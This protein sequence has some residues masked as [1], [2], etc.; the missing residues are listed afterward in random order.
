[1]KRVTLLFI[2][3]LSVTE[4]FSQIV[5]SGS[6]RYAKD[7]SVV[8]M[9]NVIIEDTQKK[10]VIGSA[11]SDET[12]RFKISCKPESSTL[13]LT[14][15]GFNIARHSQIIKAQSQEIVIEVMYQE[16]RLKGA[17]IKVE[18]IKRTGDTL[19]YYVSKF[20][21]SLDRSIG[22]VLKKM[23]GISVDRSGGI[24]YNGR[25][26]TKF[27][28]E[29]MDMMGA[30]YGVATKNVQ[31]RDI[32]AVE[33]YENHQPV[34]MFKDLK[35]SED[36]AINLKL[37][38]KSK[39]VLIATLQLGAG[40]KPWS[41]SGMLSAMLF[42]NSYQM[43]VSAKTNN[44]GEDIITE[45]VEQFDNNSIQLLPHIGVYAP[46]KPDIDIER[47]MKNTTHAISINNL[48]KLNKDKVLS[49]NSIYSYD[50]QD[51]RDSSITVYYMPSTSPLKIGEA[52]GVRSKTNHAEMRLKF[53]ENG[54]KRY[55]EDVL[56]LQ[57]KWN[58]AQGEVLTRDEMINQSFNMNPNLRVTNEFNSAKTFKN[59]LFFGFGSIIGASHLPASLCVNPLIY[60]SI[61]GYEQ[62]NDETAIQ[63]MSTQAFQT[64]EH[65][66]SLYNI[67]PR[68]VLDAMV[69]FTLDHQKMESSLGLKSKSEF[70]D[71]LCNDIISNKWSIDGKV[72]LKYKYKK[73]DIS[74]SVDIDYAFIN[75]ND[76]IKNVFTS[77][78]KLFFKPY[79]V[80]NLA[81]ALNLKLNLKSYYTEDYGATGNFYSGYILTDYRSISTRNGD[82]A[83]NKSQS[84]SIGLKYADAMSA[85]FASVDASYWRNKSNIMYGTTFN[86]DLSYIES[87]HIDNITHGYGV[88]GKVSKF[89]DNIFTTLELSGGYEQ[90]WMDIFRQHKVMNTNNITTKAGFKWI[91][92]WCKNKIKSNYT[93]NYLYNQTKYSN[94]DLNITSINALHQVLTIDYSIINALVFHLVGEHYFNNAIAYGS[95]NIYFLDA[96][97]TFKTQKIEYMLEARNL[98]NTRVY[99][100]N[101]TSGATDF[102]YHYLLRPTLVMLKVKFKLN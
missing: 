97:L 91:T 87:Y 5:I 27:Y 39:G 15:A 85:L 7:L 54:S 41:W 70:P 28:V 22:D 79:F 16:I 73:L 94:K 71:T 43:F 67:A 24:K 34:K 36:A 58:Q 23:P 78:S 40:Y 44:S 92:N 77:K 60:P 19:T 47:Y 56:T 86:G 26:I 14:V 55:I 32:A 83:E 12:G 62:A 45:L 65:V 30:R 46:A 59:G 53:T 6:I 66:Y 101:Y 88:N 75:F 61:F 17:V 90:F 29:G 63:T 2:L 72:G 25:A 10:M 82:I 35:F 31:A 20:S 33:I 95:R 50:R 18:P 102:E 48:F 64:K 84:H 52:T 4:L 49:I 96:S 81:L 100:N 11:V 21:D 8:D 68:L 37:K 74:T 69:G 13:K 93:A 9:A 80:M 89:F 99:N 76:K 42:T 57:A 51:F 98:L 38:E 1:M 3:L